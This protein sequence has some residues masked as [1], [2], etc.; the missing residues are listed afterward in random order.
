MKDW[1]TFMAAVKIT[2]WRC[3]WL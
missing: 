1:P 2:K 3:R